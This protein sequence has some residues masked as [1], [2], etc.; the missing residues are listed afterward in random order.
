MESGTREIQYTF[1][2]TAMSAEYQI[3]KDFLIDIHSGSIQ[4]EIR[5][6]EIKRNKQYNT[7]NQIRGKIYHF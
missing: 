2:T 1:L 5:S 7:K 6:R 4:N 3:N